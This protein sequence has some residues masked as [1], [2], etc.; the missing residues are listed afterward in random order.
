MTYISQES[1]LELIHFFLSS[2]L[3]HFFSIANSRLNWIF[4]FSNLSI[5]THKSGI[6]AAS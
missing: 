2:P 4:S 3:L 1:R 5:F 6:Q